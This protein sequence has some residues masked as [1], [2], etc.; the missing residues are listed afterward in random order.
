LAAVRAGAL[1]PHHQELTEL[2]VLDRTVLIGI[3]IMEVVVIITT[4][5]VVAR[6]AIMTPSE[7]RVPGCLA[8]SDM[9]DELL[10]AVQ[11][12]RTAWTVG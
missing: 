11:W 12:W 5:M 10:K 7:T 1:H 9:V 6:E 4:T 8:G 3:T 2:L